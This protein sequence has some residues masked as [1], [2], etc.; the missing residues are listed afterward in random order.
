LTKL[1]KKNKLGYREKTKKTYRYCKYAV[2]KRTNGQSELEQI[3]QY[4]MTR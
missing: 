1:T 4:A 2:R 3:M